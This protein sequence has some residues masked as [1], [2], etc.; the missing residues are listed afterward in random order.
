M[1]KFKI[2]NR[3]K[4]KYTKRSTE[5]VSF[6][7]GPYIPVKTYAPV[8]SPPSPVIPATLQNSHQ[9]IKTKTLLIYITLFIVALCSIILNPYLP[10]GYLYREILIIV[11][12]IAIFIY[13]S[14][15]L[16]IDV[17]NKTTLTIQNITNE[18]YQIIC[19]IILTII[20]T[21]DFTNTWLINQL[22]LL[23]S[24]AGH[25]II[26]YWEKLTSIIST[27]LTQTGRE[28]DTLSPPVKFILNELH[29][30]AQVLFSNMSNIFKF[31]STKTITVANS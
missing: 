20:Y 4:R 26:Y 6:K 15:L 12:Q 7:P 25:T 8:I 11:E 1:R 31:I 14:L 9:S 22:I 19:K 28:L 30:S 27:N 3:P 17:L 29:N 5:S 16:Q 24:A 21:I 18:N 23:L 2:K 13:Q 10:F